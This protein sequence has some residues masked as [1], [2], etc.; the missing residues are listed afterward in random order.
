MYLIFIFVRMLLLI[1]VDQ[2]VNPE[3]QYKVNVKLAVDGD[4]GRIAGST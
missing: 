3:N 4:R 1:L 2:G